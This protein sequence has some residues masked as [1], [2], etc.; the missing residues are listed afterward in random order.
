MKKVCSIDLDCLIT[1]EK[2]PDVLSKS[3]QKFVTRRN[4]NGTI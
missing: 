4:L 2:G 3:N 1:S